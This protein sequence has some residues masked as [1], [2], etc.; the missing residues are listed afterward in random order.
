MNT[1]ATV[2]AAVDAWRGRHPGAVHVAT[3]LDD[4]R[5]WWRGAAPTAAARTSAGGP[6]GAIALPGGVGLTWSRRTP[7]RPP[8]RAA[9]DRPRPPARDRAPVPRPPRG[10]RSATAT[11]RGRFPLADHQTVYAT[12]PGSA[13]MPSAGR[14]FTESLLVRLVARGIAVAPVVLHASVSSPELHEP[15][16]TERFTVPAAT[17]RWVEGTRAAGRR[18]VAVGTTAVRALESAAAPDGTVVAR[19]RLD[20]TSSWARP[21][22]PGGDEPRHGLDRPEASHLLLLEAVAGPGRVAEAYA[23]ALAQRVSLARVRDSML[24]L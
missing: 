10:G 19:V 20:A 9:V 8:R 13:E 2:P 3:P 14:P 17:A 11:F 7:T 12:E 15:P 5:W 16:V 4:G 1:S 18:V 23:E 24:F 22:G 6:A 21:P